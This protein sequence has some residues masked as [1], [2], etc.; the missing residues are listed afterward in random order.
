MVFSG[1][2]EGTLARWTESDLAQPFQSYLLADQSLFINS[3]WMATAQ[4]KVISSS[5]YGAQATRQDQAL[6][7]HTFVDYYP[8]DNFIQYQKG[9]HLIRAGYQQIVWGEAFGLFFS[10]FITP[11]NLYLSPFSEGEQ[12]RRSIPALNYK[13]L[14]G[15]SSSI[16]LIAIPMGQFSK[17]PPPGSI[18]G[19][20]KLTEMGIQNITSTPDTKFHTERG[21]FGLKISHSF[22]GSD[23]SIYGFSYQD[24]LP[25][26]FIDTTQFNFFQ[27]HLLERHER[28]NTVGLTGA[29]D[30]QGFIIRF[31][32]LR[33]LNKSINYMNGSTL[34]KYKSDEQVN[35]ASLDFPSWGLWNLTLQFS[36]R[37]LQKSHSGLLISRYQPSW[38]FR[39][40]RL[41]PN[42]QRLDLLGS[43]SGDDQ[44]MLSHIEYIWP[45]T[46]T[47]DLRFGGEFFSG[48]PESL[49]GSKKDLSCVFAKIHAYF[50]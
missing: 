15:E 40:S 46:R 3:Q 35:V 39:I 22:S 30:F 32:S 12:L 37:N 29:F 41:F 16:Q 45:R 13:F 24:R 6:K 48:P 27:L 14:L 1:A 26:Y 5:F 38:S 2:M 34:D 49:F 11:K 44:G 36:D 42:E 25:L 10:D 50:R 19:E 28:L 9:S 20:K 18:I 47:Y 31:E 21:D 17:M 23:F 33:H 7:D 8:G 4:I 43:Y